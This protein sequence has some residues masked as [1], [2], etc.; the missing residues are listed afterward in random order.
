[1]QGNRK[2]NMFYLLATKKG[3]LK[4]IDQNSLGQIRKNG[5]L[6]FS[7]KKEDQIISVKEV[8]QGDEIILITSQGKTIRFKEK[9][10]KIMT[11]QTGGIKTISLK[12]DDSLVDMQVKKKESE[13]LIVTENGL[14]KRTDLKEIRLQKKGGGGIMI[15]KVNEKTGKIV[16]TFLNDPLKKNLLV[17]SKKAQVLKIPFSSVPCLGRIS[18][19]V[20]L[21][22]FSDADKVGSILNF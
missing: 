8:S 18:Q 14:G 2:Y 21:I 10:I 15:S 19:G 22:K 1:M 16:K 3:F 17:I 5:L 11:R 9:E 12:K 13:I 4:K 6:V 20:R 7:L